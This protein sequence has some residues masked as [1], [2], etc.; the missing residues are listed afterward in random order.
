MPS[1]RH[2]HSS[3]FLLRWFKIFPKRVAIECASGISS[4]ISTLANPN[5]IPIPVSCLRVCRSATFR[6]VRGPS[7]LEVIYNY[8]VS[9]F[10]MTW[11]HSCSSTRTI[12]SPSSSSSSSSQNHRLRP[13]FRSHWYPPFPVLARLSS[14][15]R[16]PPQRPTSFDGFP[17]RSNVGFRSTFPCFSISFC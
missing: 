2:H 4:S 13:E 1:G 6:V 3:P 7:P 10:R 17:S 5:M 12:G 16:F 11:G 14:L 9:M 8:S 15:C